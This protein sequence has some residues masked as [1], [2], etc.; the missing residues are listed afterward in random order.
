MPQRNERTKNTN[1]G[2]TT[3]TVVV[4]S[5][6]AQTLVPA[7]PERIGLIVSHPGTQE[8]WIRFYPAAQDN[9]Q[10]GIYLENNGERTWQMTPDNIYTGEVS[11]IMDGGGNKTIHYT[12]W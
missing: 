6:T 4:N 5:S 10:T 9:D 11:V 3:G 8:L 2:A 12:E 7:N 1:D